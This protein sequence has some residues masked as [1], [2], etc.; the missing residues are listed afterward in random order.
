MCAQ[1]L[2]HVQLF[3]TL[4]TIIVHQAPLSMGFSQARILEWVA[5]SISRGSSQPS[6]NNYYQL[7]PHP[8]TAWGVH[9]PQ[10]TP[11][12]PLYYTY[13]E[14]DAERLFVPGLIFQNLQS[15]HFFPT[16]LKFVDLRRR[17]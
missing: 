9:T 5:I 14:T 3:V 13:R 6:D 4:W 1:V 16:N 8:C 15:N 11:H 2:S 12:N 7:P 10:S 17:F